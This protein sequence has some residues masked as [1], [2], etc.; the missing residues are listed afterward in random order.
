MI[1]V[2]ICGLT[3]S[4]DA[5]MAERAGA[6]YLGAIL[7]SGPR[8]L[9]LDRARDVLGA[10]RDGVRRV[11]VFGSQSVQE[12]HDIASSLELDVVQLHEHPTVEQ[13]VQLRTMLSGMV[14]PVV[15]IEGI[16]LPSNATALATAAGALVLDAKVMG[17][18]GGTGVTL[19]WAGLADAVGALRE[20]VPRV[21]LILAGGLRA[22]NVAD[23]IALL[24]PDV[25]DV[26]S[27]VESAPGVKDPEAVVEFVKAV[28]AAKGTWT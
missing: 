19:D 5:L 27:G 16:S 28:D 7:A 9:T 21:Q 22:A 2:K 18:L 24:H 12:L 15:R 26:S 6:A 4:A 11:A 20:A 3:R 25:V 10:R 13:I 23:A 8:L 14:W 1:A 17:Q